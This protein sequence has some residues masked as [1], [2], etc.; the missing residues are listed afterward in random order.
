MAITF[1][2]LNTN[3]H[4]F[5]DLIPSDWQEE[6]IPFWNDYQETSDVY[7]LLDDGQIIGGGI[8]FSKC[9][10]DILYFQKKAQE[11]FDK[12]YLYLGFIYISENRQHQNLGSLW[13]QELKKLDP[14]QCYWLVIEDFNLDRFYTKNKF[15]LDRTLHKNDQQ[16]WL[17]QFTP[18]LIPQ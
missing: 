17:Y 12:G 6:I 14:E 4:L 13:L 7:C 8:V 16:E 18:R 10:P 2:N 11:W 1:K 9:T 5:F 3:P 15:V